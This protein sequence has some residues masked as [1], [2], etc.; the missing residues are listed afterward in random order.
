M[1][2][3][4]E[5]NLG[6]SVRQ[7]PFGRFFDNLFSTLDFDF[8]FDAPAPGD[9][10]ASENPWP[11][12]SINITADVAIVLVELAGYERES[13][14]LVVEDS[15]I[16][17]SGSIDGGSSFVKTFR[18]DTERFDMDSVKAGYKNGLLTITLNRIKK[19]ETEKR[20]VTIQ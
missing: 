18:V 8:D 19:A 20:T 16:T 12:V 3:K 1:R 11:I 2:N 13:L 7:G 15:I 4:Y 6:Q 14:E 5:W 9:I 17:I 10:V